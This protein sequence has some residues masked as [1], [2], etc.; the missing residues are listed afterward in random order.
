[1]G[2]VVTRQRFHEG[3]V[4]GAHDETLVDGQRS[5]Q[6]EQTAL[7]AEGALRSEWVLI[8]RFFFLTCQ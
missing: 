6:T 3:D 5:R 2:G 4:D 1:M 8:R 7:Y